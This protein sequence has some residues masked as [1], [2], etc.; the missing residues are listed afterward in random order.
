VVL[1]MHRAWLLIGTAFIEVGTGLALLVVPSVPLALLLGVSVAVPEALLVGRVAG[2]ALL[3]LGV[4]S[5]L[6][7]D[8]RQGRAQLGLLTGLLIYDGVAAALLGYAGLGMS[9]AGT[10]LWP[11][12]VLHTA[13]AAW[14]LVCLCVK[15][16]ARWGTD[17]NREVE[18]P[19]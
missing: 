13:L 11:A 16:P 8:D 18:P 17:G 7:R 14:C 6:G 12:V 15:P 19:E 4:A 10:L 5:W 9:M 1:L 3:A 2:A